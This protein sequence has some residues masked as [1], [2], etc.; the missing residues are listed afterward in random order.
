MALCI[1]TSMIREFTLDD[2]R[3]LIGDGMSSRRISAPI[4]VMV[5]KHFR[6]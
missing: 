6:A 1:F 3:R 2:A 5:E 4:Q